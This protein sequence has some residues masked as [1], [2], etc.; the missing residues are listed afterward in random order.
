MTE[1]GGDDRRENDDR[2][3][4]RCQRKGMMTEEPMTTGGVQRKRMGMMT[5]KVDQDR[6]GTMTEEE[7]DNRR[8]ED[9]P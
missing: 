4:V 1:D 5:E 8:G 7:N 9:H 6:R 2:G 3:R